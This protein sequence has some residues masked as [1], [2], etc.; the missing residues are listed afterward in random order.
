MNTC[1]GGHGG[2]AGL[3]AFPGRRAQQVD[4][5]YRTDDGGMNWTQIEAVDFPHSADQGLISL[6]TA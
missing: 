2:V 3:G 4:G 1:V 6:G 5:A